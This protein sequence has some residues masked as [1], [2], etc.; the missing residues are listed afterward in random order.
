MAGSTVSASM[1]RR[2]SVRRGGC[3]QFFEFDAVEHGRRRI[4]LSNVVDGDDLEAA[5]ENCSAP[6]FVAQPLRTGHHAS[7]PS[8][9]EAPRRTVVVVG[10]GVA[11]AVPDRCIIGVTLRATRETVA[12]AIAEV[13]SLADAAMNALR[14]A[15]VDGSDLSTQNVHVQ[16]WI[17]HQQQ[18]VTARIATYT[19][20]VTVR[21]LG[22]VSALVNL[23]AETVG[24]ALQ[25]QGIAFSHSDS[26][27]LLA[28]AR[29][30]AVADAN[31]RAEQLADAAAARIGQ[32]LSIDEGSATDGGWT[33]Y[34]AASR[35]AHELSG[36]AMPMNPGAHT[37]T[38]R[39]VITYSL[40]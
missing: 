16:D 38:A 31:A 34:A 29:R 24:D 11:N 26:A 36:P 4:Y 19:F 14:R 10:H 33:G 37:V 22:E 3:A 15:S 13:A 23:L 32:I 5:P 40:E 12:E 18:R 9:D 8:G 6:A 20:T 25:I 21:D 39:V 17:D 2:L 35:A 30:D 7:V 27:S 28:D 1:N